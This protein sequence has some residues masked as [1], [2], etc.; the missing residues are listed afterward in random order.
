MRT[1]LASSGIA[2][3]AFATLALGA[4]TLAGPG[5]DKLPRCSEVKCKDIG[6][7]ADVLCVSGAKVK[8]C[9]EVCG[10]H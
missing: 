6:C 5:S 1:R 9:A 8:S 10:G 3:V 7:P 4:V 2:L